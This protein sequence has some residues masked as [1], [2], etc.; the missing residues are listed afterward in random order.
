M[1]WKKLIVSGSDAHLNTITASNNNPLSLPNIAQS[2][3][4]SSDYIL[5]LKT[6]GSVDKVIPEILINYHLTNTSVDDNNIPPINTIVNLQR[7]E[8]VRVGHGIATPSA[9]EF[10]IGKVDSSEAA[11]QEHWFVWVE[12]DATNTGSFVFETE[13]FDYK[14][15]E[16][17]GADVD[18][19]TNDRYADYGQDFYVTFVNNGGGDLIIAHNNSQS[20]PGQDI[21]EFAPMVSYLIY[22]NHSQ[23]Y[24]VTPKIFRDLTGNVDTYAVFWNPYGSTLVRT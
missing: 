19:N 23:T 9:Q 2:I 7:N 5:R 12:Y 22:N 20:Y 11:R 6:D 18:D 21:W 1:S 24:R 17:F 3:P 14:N 16:W 15:C 10:K 4:T 8:D 13:W